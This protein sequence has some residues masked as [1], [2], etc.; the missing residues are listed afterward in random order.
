MK[1]LLVFITLGCAVL[2]HTLAA[3]DDIDLA[4][5]VKAAYLFNFAR[6]IQWP[7]ADAELDASVF[8]LCIVGDPKIA[9]ALEDAKSNDIGNRRLNVTLLNNA[10][11]VQ[12]CQLVFITNPTGGLGRA[13]L[14]DTRNLPILTVVDAGNPESDDGMITLLLV[15]GRLRF[16]VNQQAAQRA[17]LRIPAQVL[18]LAENVS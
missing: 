12:H 17:G 10:A 6:F 5:Q 9:R 16:R 11:T 2:T 13:I 8:N 14:D 18:K 15:D 7:K 4:T 3:A 1:R